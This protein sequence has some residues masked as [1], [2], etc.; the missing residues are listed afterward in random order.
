[1]PEAF[2]GAG[3]AGLA[4]TGGFGLVASGGPGGLISSELE[5][6]ETG[7]EAA[8]AVGVFFHGVADPF[9]GPMPGNTATGLLEASADIELTK[10]FGAAGAAGRLGGGGGDGAG[11]ALGGTSSR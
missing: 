3:G 10:D 8:D 1:M 5:G 2:R 11:V 4:P 9:E 7:A 6:R